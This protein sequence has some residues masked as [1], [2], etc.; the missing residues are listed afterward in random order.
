M[1]RTAIVLSGLGA[2]AVA[3]ALALPPEL[4]LLALALLVP[5]GLFLGALGWRVEAADTGRAP[6]ASTVAGL[7][8]LALVSSLVLPV[9]PPAV[10][11]MG[12]IVGLPWILGILA[13]AWRAR[14]ADPDV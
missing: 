9:L 11:G 14:R 6:E 2:A 10:L 4:T 12:L 3:L 7:L 5:W 1:Y 13:L 8:G